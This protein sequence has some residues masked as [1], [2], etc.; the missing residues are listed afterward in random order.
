[1]SAVMGFLSQE[2]SLI[3]NGTGRIPV[4]FRHALISGATGS[5]KTSSLI[6]PNINDRIARGH[7]V[8]VFD[9]KGHEHLKVKALATSHNRLRD[10]LEIGKPYGAYIN[11]LAMLDR[12]TFENGIIDMG[13][14]LSARDPYWIRSAA[15]LA[16][17]I[18]DVLRSA[19]RFFSLIERVLNLPRLSMSVKISYTIRKN[20]THEEE[21]DFP[22]TESSF[23]T[24]LNVCRT[25]LELFKFQT[26][27]GELQNR[28]EDML[29]TAAAA[30]KNLTAAGSPYGEDSVNELLLLGSELN[31]FRR[32]VEILGS[33]ETDVKERGNSAGNN[34][35]LQIL[36]N[37]LYGA[38]KADF[39]NSGEVDLVR[40]LEKGAIVI[41]D[42]QSVDAHVYGLLLESL[43]KRLGNRTRKKSFRPVSVFIDEANR[44]LPGGEDLHVDVLR[45][46]K[47]ELVLAVQNEQQMLVRY[48]QT[49][50]EAI[51]ENLLHRYEIDDTHRVRTGEGR[52]F[53]PEPMLFD[54]DTLRESEIA[55]HDL[56]ES[57]RTLADRFIGPRLPSRYTVEYSPY[58]FSEQLSITVRDED[59]GEKT[60]HKYAGKEGKADIMKKV[61][62]MLEADETA[63][64]TEAGYDF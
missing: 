37:V 51:A 52:L 21:Y 54:G 25:S 45:E 46:A 39:L 64:E 5:G 56:E 14:G 40:E 23:S 43:L 30:A 36:Q 62:S 11:L 1:M 41:I 44:V 6:T 27:C 15:S 17:S 53:H 8:I 60:E 33:F 55:F 2:N 58:A 49:A 20:E 24:I 18:F 28:M 50:W 32:D 9:H 19:N 47:V 57:R 31:T 13:G 4:D 48:G 63:D 16:V 12:K 38:G 34:G 42:T 59:T 10:V 61:M 7:S 35:V 29:D 26:A 3:D 22:V